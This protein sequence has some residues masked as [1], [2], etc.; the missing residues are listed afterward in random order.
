[1]AA[2]AQR[3]AGAGLKAH[4]AV[5][6]RLGLHTGRLPS[7]LGSEVTWDRRAWGAGVG[8]L[9]LTIEPTLSLEMGAPV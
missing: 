5:L 9:A 1:M 2:E 7:E 6:G 3:G 8:I 4:G